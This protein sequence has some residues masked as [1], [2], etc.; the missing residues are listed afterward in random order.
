VLLVIR[1]RHGAGL[2]AAAT[3][4]LSGLLYNHA[5]RFIR[6]NMTISMRRKKQR[7]ANYLLLGILMIFL[8]MLVACGSGEFTPT[9]TS[10]TA[11]PLPVTPIPTITPSRPLT[12]CLGQEPSSL[13]PV[14]NPSMAAR[15]VLAAVYDGPIDTNSYGYEPVI[16][17]TIPSL[18][19][20]D[21]QLFKKSVYIGDEVVDASNMPVTL[22]TGMRIRPAGC[23]SDSCAVVYDGIG[24][25]DMDQM[26]VTFRLLPGLT[27]S[28]GLP[29]TASDSVYAYNLVAD[30]GSANPKFIVER[31]QSYEAADDVTVQ[32]WGKP[33]FIDPTYLTNFWMPLPQHLWSTIPLDQLQKA[34]ESS[35]SPVGWGPYVIQGWVTGDHI[36][37]TKN[38]RYFRA[39][40]GLPKFTSL[41]FRFVP[42]PPTALSDLIA[43]TCDILDPSINLDGQVNLLRSM[44]KQKQLQVLFTNPPVMEQ[45]AFGIHPA[46][47]DNG[48]NAGFDRPDFLG[49]VR[50]RQ[51][52]A[53]CIDR[54]NIVDSVLQGLSTVPDSFVPSDYPLYVSGATTYAIDVAAAN[55]L[56]DQ[57]GWKDL[58]NNLLT[59]R[60]AIG[61]KNVPDGTPLELNYITTGAA[62]RV[63]VSTSI[64]DSLAQCGIKID[65]KYLDQAVLYAAGPDGSL[66]GRDFE[67][68]EFAM[69]SAG[70]EPPCDWFTSSEIPNSTNYWVGTNVSGYSNPAFDAACLTVEQSLY[71][72]VSH[73]DAYHL[74]QSIFLHD[75]PVLPLYWRINIAA[76]RPEV[77]NFSLDPTA[78]SPLWNIETFDSGTSCGP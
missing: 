1:I 38:E 66:F 49:D 51:A 48:Y 72:E 68:A 24:S 9:A 2:V 78:S 54:Q 26:Q 73:A 77:C 57:V 53:M 33:G 21:A 67:L 16:L 76:A 28:D 70:I 12:I 65:V 44:T 36:T 20:G 27:W 13:F 35:R 4:N 59:P 56:L 71:D 42:D 69:G 10:V 5:M 58:D 40:E 37:L 18:A 62:Q 11:S 19:N 47:Y 6:G 23:R 29:L 46:V 52:I 74:T 3:R 55:N 15:S 60:R 39:A 25:I 32:W 63:Q 75:L 41:T 64:R 61:V 31:T 14:D 43:G 17:K 50:T 34:P 22:A 45:L 7:H 30:P 8:G